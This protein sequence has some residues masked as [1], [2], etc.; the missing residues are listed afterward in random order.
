M[1]HVVALANNQEVY[2]RDAIPPTSK[3]ATNLRHMRYH[4][5]PQ[6]LTYQQATQGV[7]AD[8]LA[9]YQAQDPHDPFGFLFATFVHWIFFER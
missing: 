6:F 4:V 1:D 3:K 5:I 9:F 7:A 2:E 8:T